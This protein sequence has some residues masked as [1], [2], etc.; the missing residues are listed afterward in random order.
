MRGGNPGNPCRQTFS[1]KKTDCSERKIDVCDKR[2]DVCDKRI[3]VCDKRID[4]CRKKIS[5]CDKRIDVCRK[6][7]DVCGKRISVCGENTDVCG[8]KVNKGG[9]AIT[10][11]L[12]QI[13]YFA[14][15]IASRALRK[16]APFGTSAFAESVLV[17][18]PLASVAEIIE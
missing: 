1:E 3:A 13:D 2:I 6:N 4:V 15:G 17:V 14:C 9:I 12:L 5:V 8:F 18:L 10:I 11:R 7:I 16:A